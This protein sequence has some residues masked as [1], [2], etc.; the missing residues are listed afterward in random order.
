MKRADKLTV[1]DLRHWRLLK[2]F[3][4][5]LKP[6]VS[7]SQMHPTFSD[8]RRTLGFAPYLSLF[9]FGLFNPVVRS[10]RQLCAMSQLDKVQQ[11][12]GCGHVSLGSFSETQAVLEPDLLKQVF[13]RLVAQMPESPKADPQLQHLQL[14]AQD[15]SLWSA[16]PRM[17]W[18]EYGVGSKG[19][20]K[21]VR[22]HLRFNI[23]KDC[24]ED[25]FVTEGKG[26]E[27]Q[28]LRQMLVP[29][30]TTVGDR[31]YGQSYKLFQDI[32][33]TKAFFVF[34]LNDKAVIEVEEEL[35][36]SAAEVQAGVIRH[37]WVHLG[38]T[39]KLRSMRVRLV[40]I[41]REGQHLLLVTNHRVETLSAELVSLLYRRRWSIELFFRWIKCILGTRHFFAESRA[42]VTIEIYL[43]LIAALLL[44]LLTGERPNKRVMELLQLYFLGWATAEELARLIP[45]YSARAKSTPKK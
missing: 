21:G 42:G 26:S 43:A 30:Q 2:V 4:E 17:A 22:L 3:L 8:R 23:L 31:L 20:A 32:E 27:T 25:A 16:L 1:K 40:E 9:L 11:T 35:P 38:A 37:A 24:P 39:E 10:L 34:R 45:K 12:T 41:R 13:E 44:Q 6:V 33:Q 19:L 14:I 7:K 36:L 28:V 18:A 29:G 5:A 15:G